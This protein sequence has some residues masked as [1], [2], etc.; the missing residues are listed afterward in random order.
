MSHTIRVHVVNRC[1]H[2]FEEVA[3]DGLFEAAAGRDE[4]E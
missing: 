3:A 2:L 4:V 1:E